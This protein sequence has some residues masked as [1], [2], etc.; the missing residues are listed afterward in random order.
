MDLR[1]HVRQLPSYRVFLVFWGGLALV[2]LTDGLGATARVILM[3]ALVAACC[4]RATR[5]TVLLVA[6]T[7]WLL[8]NGFVVNNYGQL[9][10]VGGTDVVR[11][12]LLVGVGLA[13][14]GEWSRQVRTAP[15][16]A[17]SPISTEMT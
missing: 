2:G 12:L 7:A 10:L 14:S 3:A 11:L 1:A 17:R 6:G 16:P 13:A 15:D 5:M 9:H 8:V 4:R